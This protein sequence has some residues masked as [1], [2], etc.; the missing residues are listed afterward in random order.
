MAG[1]GRKG[2]LG[3]IVVGVVL[4]LAGLAPQ[5]AQAET[6]SGCD[7]RASCSDC[8]S[9]Q[10]PCGNRER[11]RPCEEDR[12]PSCRDCYEDRDERPCRDC[13]DDDRKD[14]DEKKK[15]DDY[16]DAK[17]SD[18]KKKGDDEKK[19]GDDD[20]KDSDKDRSRLRKLLPGHEDQNLGEAVRN[21]I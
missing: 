11:S 19:K 16:D 3:A 13:Y 20:G 2:R 17:R 7:R 6:R 9:E 5:A 18:E 12:R 15:G 1:T 8:Y 4:G 10:R 21:L 14:S